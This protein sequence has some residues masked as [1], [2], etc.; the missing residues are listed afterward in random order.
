MSTIGSMVSLEDMDA[1]RRYCHY[2]AEE[3]WKSQLDEQATC[4]SCNGPI[5]KG[6]GFLLGSS[7]YCSNCASD[8]FGTEGMM[9]LQADPNFFG[10]GLVEKARAFA[11]N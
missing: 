4:D 1:I 10:R 7:L 3:W 6:G 8:Q 11:N 5:A 2:L 9:R